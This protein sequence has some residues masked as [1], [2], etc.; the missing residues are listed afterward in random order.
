MHG[1]G[2]NRGYFVRFRVMIN[3]LSPWLRLGLRGRLLVLIVLILAL[4]RVVLGGAQMLGEMEEYWSALAREMQPNLDQMAEDLA[5]PVVAGN[6]RA[7][8]RILVARSGQP[9]IGEI[10][11]HDRAAGTVMRVR[12]EKSELVRPPSW[13]QG[14]LALKPVLKSR[15]IV[16]AGKDYGTLQVEFSGLPLEIRLWNQFVA[17]AWQFVLVLLLLSAAVFMLLGKWLR[18][19]ERVAA[20]GRRFLA[21][22]YGQ[23]ISDSSRLVPEVRTMVDILNQ[24]AA[25]VGGLVLSLSEQRRAIDNAVIVVE[26]DLSGIVYYVND[27]FCEVSGYSRGEVVGRDHRLLKS[28]Y[29][30]PEFFEELWRTVRRGETWQGEICN[31]TRSGGILWLLA[32]ITPVLGQ[33]GQPFKYISVWV[34]IT[35]R[36]LAENVLAQQAQIIDQTRE[37]VFSTDL[38]GTLVSWNRGAE[39]LFGYSAN[40]A[41]GQPMRF[42]LPEAAPGTLEESV[43][44][45]VFQNGGVAI[46]TQLARK[47]A[48]AFDAHFSLTLLKD[49]EGNQIGVTGYVLDMTARKNMERA[50]R[51]SE[52]RLAK[53]Q[54]MAHLGSWE[55]D[56][57]SDV[58]VRSSEVARIFDLAPESKLDSQGFFMHV[59]PA[60][61]ELVEKSVI[62]AL[63][64]EITYSL[65]FRIVTTAGENRFVHAEGEV[66]WDAQGKPRRM[67]GTVQDI[68]DRQLAE[69]EIRRSREQ[70][71]ELSAHL[72]TAREEEKA[73]I[74]REIHDELGGNL[75]ALKMD[76]FWLTRKLPV[77]LD[78][79]RVKVGEMANMVDASV[80]AMRRIVT[81]LRPTLLDDLGLLPAMKWQASEF[82]KRYGVSCSVEM[83]GDEVDMDEA[84]RIALFRI[85]QEALTNVARYANATRVQ[86]DVW[87]E[88]DKI[89][90][91]LID[92]GIG[93]PE[94]AIMQPTSHGIR[95]MMERAHALGGSVEIGS[96]PGEGVSISVRIPIAAE[97]FA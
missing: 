15:N 40:E 79:A 43:I 17:E 24:A 36:K 78:A 20:A 85:F 19:L 64:G 14:Y 42:I 51:E 30:P 76:I 33:D 86:V 62:A 72:Q 27:K 44:L 26:S 49:W 84:R 66:E 11:W 65:D 35:R 9:R 46:E 39:L 83:H 88:H 58:V 73:V 95:G 2:Y 32:T 8:Q 70:L 59:H 75:T 56:V 6:S 37:A 74:A 81:E 55:W 77:E 61:R 69:Q 68:T 38:K 3:F 45:S 91:D 97:V 54:Q 53:A 80:H 10:A 41:I 63:A 96:A 94:G 5:G 29:H 34:D 47:D 28:G 4:G 52:A 25:R 12:A 50:L 21:G 16:V 67:I 89:A 13:F 18:P 71:R 22:D 1:C 23:R 92:N 57:A 48:P 31:Q 60:D 90:M 82:A 87:R 93:I 7:I